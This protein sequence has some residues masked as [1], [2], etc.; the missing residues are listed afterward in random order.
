MISI[1]T[2]CYTIRSS[3]YNNSSTSNLHDKFVKNNTRSHKIFWELFSARISWF[4][5]WNLTSD[6]S[7][8]TDIM[9]YHA[10][11]QKY[12]FCRCQTFIFLTRSATKRPKSLQ[13]CLVC[14]YS[15]YSS[16]RK[17]YRRLTETPLLW[18]GYHFKMPRFVYTVRPSQD[19]RHYAEVYSNA[20]SWE[21]ICVFWPRFHSSFFCKY[22]IGRIED[23]PLS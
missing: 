1:G 6:I 5:W 18:H 7:T 11:V 14:P 16:D 12:S 3:I 8:A 21:K 4:S 22:S 15:M 23:K 20:F 17:C 13:L 10:T 19:G 9:W 2:I